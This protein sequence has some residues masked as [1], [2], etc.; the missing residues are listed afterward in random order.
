[1][2]SKAHRVGC[3]AD[4]GAG[5]KKLT[6]V[7]ITGYASECTKINKNLQI[8]VHVSILATCVPRLDELCAE[9]WNEHETLLA[10][11]LN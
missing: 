11:T 4:C 2:Y 1:M 9:G 7:V 6:E 3:H 5:E 8:Y 10:W